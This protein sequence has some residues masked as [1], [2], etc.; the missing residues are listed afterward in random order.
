MLSPVKQRNTQSLRIA[1]LPTMTATMVRNKP[2]SLARL[3]FLTVC[4]SNQN[5]LNST[6]ERHKWDDGVSS[7]GASWDRLPLNSEL[8]QQLRKWMDAWMNRWGPHAAYSTCFILFNEPFVCVVCDIRLPPLDRTLVWQQK[9]QINR[10]CLSNMSRRKVQL[11]FVKYTTDSQI[12]G[13]GTTIILEQSWTVKQWKS[14]QNIYWS[15]AGFFFTSLRTV[16]KRI[17]S[18]FYLS[19]GF[20]FS[21][22]GSFRFLSAHTQWAAILSNS[23]GLAIP[24]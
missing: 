5:C 17:Q 10:P 2:T 3:S 9:A 4:C 23:F 12:R 22:S 14:N 16:A 19:T 6:C 11:M 18:L 24:P 13:N 8:D 1:S 7:Y 20:C 21:W 15:V